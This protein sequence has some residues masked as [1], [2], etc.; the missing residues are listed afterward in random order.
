MA[1]SLHKITSK[2]SLCSASSIS[3]MGNKCIYMFKRLFRF[4]TSLKK[5][6]T[7]KGRRILHR[8]VEKEE[9]QYASSHCLSSYYS[10]FVVRLAIM[11]SEQNVMLFLLLQLL[12]S[13][14]I[15]KKKNR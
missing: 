15:L 1:S 5:S 8:D 2:S 4:A 14:F 10:V 6:I 9:F 11:V 13:L 7:P 12:Y 3:P